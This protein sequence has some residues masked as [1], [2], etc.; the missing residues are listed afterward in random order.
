MNAV[1]EK[2]RTLFDPFYHLEKEI[3]VIHLTLR[4]KVKI[5]DKEEVNIL[6]QVDALSELDFIDDRIQAL[7]P[8]KVQ[9]CKATEIIQ[10][11][12]Q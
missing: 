10:Y 8:R 5:W 9:E 11:D 12:S 2:V 3:E 4:E 7:Q 1:E 6:E